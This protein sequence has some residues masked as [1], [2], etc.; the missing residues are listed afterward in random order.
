MRG[1]LIAL[2][3]VLLLSAGCVKV[4]TD[5]DYTIVPHVQTERGGDESTPEGLTAYALYGS[6]EKWIVAS[7][8]DALAGI[9]TDTLSNQTRSYSLAAVQDG[10]G[11]INMRLTSSPVVIAVVDEADGM[12]AWRG[13]TLTDNLW[14]LTVPVRFRT[15]RTDYTYSESKWT[16]VNEAN[17]PLGEE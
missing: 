2:L 16:V 17:A 9:F 10:Q 7:Y 1:G 5:C 8:A 4:K 6:A 15:W 12:Y 3:A 11:N 14:T 13:V